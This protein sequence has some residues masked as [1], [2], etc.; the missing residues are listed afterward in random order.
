ML[1]AGYGI[2]GGLLF[3]AYDLTDAIKITITY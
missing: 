3:K 2:G 1:V